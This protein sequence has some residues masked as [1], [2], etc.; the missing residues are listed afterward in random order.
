MKYTLIAQ[1]FL[2]NQFVGDLHHFASSVPRLV[3]KLNLLHI[4]EKPVQLCSDVSAP[5]LVRRLRG[6]Q[7]IYSKILAPHGQAARRRQR[8][9][10]PHRICSA[11]QIRY[12]V[13]HIIFVSWRNNVLTES[14]FEWNSD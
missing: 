7:K 3:S 6:I 4:A 11:N 14:S 5:R 12:T 13:R 8:G 9:N 10:L 1:F 2:P